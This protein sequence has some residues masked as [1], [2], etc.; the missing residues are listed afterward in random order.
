MRPSSATSTAMRARRLQSN[1]GRNGGRAE[2]Q[3]RAY[4]E[5]T[6]NAEPVSAMLGE[7][8][9]SPKAEKRQ[10]SSDLMALL[11]RAGLP[12]YLVHTEAA[13]ANAVSGIESKE[14]QDGLGREQP[15]ES[16]LRDALKEWLRADG[17]SGQVPFQSFVIFAEYKMKQAASLTRRFPLPNRMR[18]AVTCLCLDKASKVLK[19]YGGLLGTI[20]TEVGRAAYVNYDNLAPSLAS[21]WG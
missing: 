14:V 9:Q 7:P 18:T 2:N 20:A 6:G 3:V 15:T 11:K 10:P 8:R 4:V 19:N 13:A 17:R 5:M 16:E 21:R 12:E 1:F